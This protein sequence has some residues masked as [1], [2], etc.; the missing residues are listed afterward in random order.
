M[1]SMNLH[2]NVAFFFWSLSDLTKEIYQI[3]SSTQHECLSGYHEFRVRTEM[4]F[5]FEEM[6]TR[7]DRPISD[8]LI[9]LL[10]I[11][12]HA[13]DSLDSEDPLFPSIQRV[14][15]AI[16]DKS[17]E[18]HISIQSLPTLSELLG[19]SEPCFKEPGEEVS[20]T[21]VAG[22]IL[23]TLEHMLSLA[24]IIMWNIPL[25]EP[26]RFGSYGL[27]ETTEYP[28]LNPAFWS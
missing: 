28:G 15:K 3:A 24:G 19:T 18:L 4:E 1:Y 21:V 13:L 25:H 10:V 16:Q 2:Q 27:E 6:P 8:L 26:N 14:Q 20:D 23:G 22:R 5:R 9:F 7:L 12:H 11:T 17:K